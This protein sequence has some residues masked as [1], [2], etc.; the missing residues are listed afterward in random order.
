MFKFSYQLSRNLFEMTYC[1]ATFLSIVCICTPITWTICAW[2]TSN[3]SYFS[4]RNTLSNIRKLGYRS[5]ILKNISFNSYW[6]SRLTPKSTHKCN[7]NSFLRQENVL[8]EK[9]SKTNWN[10]LRFC[11]FI[12]FSHLFLVS[13]LSHLFFEA[14]KI[15]YR[16]TSY[17]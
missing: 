3:S 16:T 17:N 12:Q 14:I 8:T 13:L 4:I 5:V 6:L 7:L 2:I 10:Y 11:L 15:Y 9:K 1:Y